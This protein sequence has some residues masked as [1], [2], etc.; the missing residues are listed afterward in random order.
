MKPQPDARIGGRA[1]NSRE[2]EELMVA[3]TLLDL[4][5]RLRT[6]TRTR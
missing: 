3:L 2:E 1:R 4:S 6:K 5:Q